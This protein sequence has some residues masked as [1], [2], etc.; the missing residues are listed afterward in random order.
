M[1]DSREQKALLYHES[2]Q[3]RESAQ[4]EAGAARD[5]L[6]AYNADPNFRE[7]VEALAALLQR[8]KS[9]KNLGKLL[10]AMTRAATVPE[11]LSR[12]H[13]LH[14]QFVLE[15]QQDVS[16]ARAAFEQAV[17]DNPD[18]AAA[19]LE[20]ELVAGKT[21]DAEL[22]VRALEERIRLAE[23][24]AWKALLLIDLA[25]LRQE[26]DDTDGALES[27][28]EARAI[29]SPAR[30]RALQAIEA[31]ASR[32]QRDEL[33]A[34][35]LKQ[36]A[37]LVLLAVDDADAGE[38]N[39]VPLFVR[40][41]VY[42]ADLFVRAADARRRLGDADGA[43][44]L[45]DLA[46]AKLPDDP[47]VMHLRRKAAE[48]VG[49]V[50]TAAAIAAR[51]IENGS[52]GRAAAAL[53]M[54][55]F[56]AAAA[57]GRRD[58][59][60]EALAKALA[61]DP[62]CIPARS[63]QIDLIVDADPAAFAASLEA[64]AEEGFSDEAKGRAYLLSSWAWA[65]RAGDV[66]G[67]KAALSQAAM[68]GVAPGSVSRL[69]RAFA[70]AIQDDVW[71]EDATRRLLAA[72]A[73]ES[74]HV[75]L[76]F[77]LARLRL[78][79]SDDDGARQALDA[80]AAVPGGL[81]LGRVLAAYVLGFRGQG[82]ARKLAPEPLELLASA[83]AD[84]TMARALRVVA[85]I[86]RAGAGQAELALDQLRELHQSDLDDLLVMSML[87]DLE[88]AAVH[89]PQ[90][91][92][93]IG[94][95]A[96]AQDDA[97]VS[98]ALH[99][100]AAFLLW[101]AGDRAKAVEEI[102]AARAQLP[103]AASVL[104]S[105]AAAAVE[106]DSIEGRRK[107]LELGEECGVDRIALALER[108]AVESNEGG[109]E[110]LATSA[111]DTLEREALGELGVAG[112][113]G[114]LVYPVGQDD[115]E[116]R[117]RALD[118]LETLGTKAS[119]VVAAERYRAAR[120]QDQDR[121]R[122]RDAA[123][124]W[125]LADGG[126]T[127]ALEWCAA[128]RAAEDAEAE[129]SALRMA[130]RHLPD[131]ASAALHS[132]A[133]LVELIGAAAGQHPAPVE[134]SEASARL[135]NL[136]LAPAGCDPRRRAAA[137]QGLGDV[138]G[139][140]ASL[141]AQMLAGWSLLASGD[142]RGALQAFQVVTERRDADLVAWEGVRTA[143]EVLDDVASQARACEKLGEL[144]RSDARS[145]EFFEMA[146]LLWIDRGG[147]EA[148][149]EKNLRAAF[150]K[151]LR[152]FVAFD[153]L[154][155]RVRA[156][157]ENDELLALIARRLEVA[158][159]TSEIAKLF[160]EQARVL[161][162]KG[163]FEGAMSALDNVTMLEP[164]HVGALALAGEVYIRRGDFEQAVEHLARL[165]KHPEAPAQQRL[166]SG[167][168]AVD[169][170]E[171]RLHRNDKALE[172]LRALSGSGLSTLPV[173]ERLARC[174][175]Q[176]QAWAEATSTLETLMRERSTAEGRIE[177]ARLAMVIYRDKVNDPPA[178]AS[179][180]RHLLEESPA[181]PEALNLLI[182]HTSV[183]DAPT[184]RRLFERARGALVGA[185][186]PSQLDDSRVELLS[187]I[188]QSQG[189]SALRQATLGTLMAL[190]GANE[191]AQQ[192]LEALDQRTARIPQV[193]L[194]DEAM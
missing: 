120:T 69:A 190:R 151:D 49:D 4:D 166:V 68:F 74:E 48:A 114:R 78:L 143:A 194:S 24:A 163:D 86:R 157:E 154:F 3:I 182:L 37:D 53:W 18:E 73:L 71:F 26:R 15:Q 80:L 19:W 93:V 72:G 97:Q 138:L 176:N 29:D 44:A 162:Q 57:G 31:I 85:A 142:E 84:P 100:E 21:S 172:I 7:P 192:E 9:F 66:S 91:A 150:D 127:P 152:R 65:V 17:S 135:M 173:R 11:Q 141:D 2:A 43:T 88:R 32:D 38:R 22:R 115:A 130:A 102:S 94:A 147:D 96:A 105:W 118:G 64:M 46:V 149:G 35:V 54:S 181:D 112:W 23:P 40:A 106:P 109:D 5:Y 153:R 104:L 82:E 139:E 186:S 117:Q 168:A 116:A 132:A 14:G 81:W 134:S 125:A 126:L 92:A 133:A 87:A 77:E 174:A 50:D 16:G 6:A 99:M 47:A 39:G 124:A 83:E 62:G 140:D 28:Q 30:F 145:A 95:S 155:R 34:E 75:S 1:S 41:P 42:V 178:A 164:D 156:R 184:R 103:A 55:V 52:T 179:A 144:C 177:A 161:R 107:V 33:I 136:E 56:E 193:K 189:D 122:A 25:R 171:N 183:G 108:V 27:L 180:V 63:L 158:E 61:L 119:A 128:G 36:Q 148:R 165:A 13:L 129:V 101:Q 60:V 98:S 191:G 169:L 51:M 131:A 188:A 12:A 121:D 110:D 67:A 146:A 70:S 160:W 45:L 167:M 59:A 79:R 10:E 58:D 185:M 8:R 159:D 111:L 90:A 170:C 187:R 20:L 89:L 175:A 137:L 123:Q 76:W 113:L